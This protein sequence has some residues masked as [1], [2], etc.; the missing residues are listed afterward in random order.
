MEEHAKES[1]KWKFWYM[2]ML[3]NLTILFYALVII[4]LLIIPAPYKIP[5]SILFFIAAIIMTWLS[6]RIYFQTK[7]WLDQNVD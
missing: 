7:G 1:F 3:L 4:F 2:T 5:G 6:R